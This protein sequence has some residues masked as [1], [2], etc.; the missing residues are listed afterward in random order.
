MAGNLINL[1]RRIKSVK[2]TQKLTKAMKTVAA[3]KLRRAMNELKKSRPHRDKITF[4]MQQ[5][6]ALIDLQQQPLLKMREQGSILLVVVAS[7]RGLCGAFNSQ[8]L[9]QSENYY[10]E[11]IE[12]GETVFLV[13]VGTKASRYFNKRG[14]SIKSAHNGMINRLQFADARSLATELLNV[15]QAE[16]IKSIEFA[17]HEFVS[18]SKQQFTVRRLLPIAMEWPATT[19]AEKENDGEKTKYIIEPGA[20][21]IFQAL[22]PR[23]I[24][25]AVYQILLQSMAA[26]QISRMVAM[27]MATRN[28]SDMIRSL[29]LLLNKMRQASITKEL[30]EII[31][32]TEALN[33]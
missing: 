26:E 11:L 18:A 12:R 17:F 30:L 27:D 23:F 7:D 20:A 28:A 19:D 32:A 33:E 29:T 31:T 2:N 3:A 1:R 22:L 5:T 6:G 9:K 13:T 8:V 16:E 4:L 14:L 21:A 10:R 25:A 15:Y 24:T